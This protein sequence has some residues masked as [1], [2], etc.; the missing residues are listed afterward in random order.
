MVGLSTWLADAAVDAVHSGRTLQI[1]TPADSLVTYP[2]EVLLGQAGGQWVVGTSATT[3]ATASPASALHW[4]GT[5]FVPTAGTAE[6]PLA[7][8]A[9]AGGL[10]SRS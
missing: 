8:L 1:V 7:G 9:W 3:T 6:R 10:E 4:D 5:R 2:L